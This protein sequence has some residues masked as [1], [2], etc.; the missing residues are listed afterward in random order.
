MQ[1]LTEEG[2]AALFHSRM[3]SPYAISF[4]SFSEEIIPRPPGVSEGIPFV[5]LRR[6]P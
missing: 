5:V 4:E 2:S 1:A 6:Q 3:N